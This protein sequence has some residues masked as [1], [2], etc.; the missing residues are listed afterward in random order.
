LNSSPT[1]PDHASRVR[2]CMSSEGSP[3]FRP[4]FSGSY[5]SKPFSREPM[6]RR[7]L[8]SPSLLPSAKRDINSLG[9]LICY[10][11]HSLPTILQV[12]QSRP[13]ARTLRSTICFRPPPIQRG[14]PN[15]IFPPMPFSCLFGF[16][17]RVNVIS[18]E[19]EPLFPLCK[20]VLR[21]HRLPSDAFVCRAN[22]NSGSPA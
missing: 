9:C 10:L 5:F 6:Y 16:P 20:S 19:P 8:P 2:H 7:V 21:A 22:P 11:P 18:V 17:P 3:G 1:G 12:T 13:P 4:V 15:L 14:R